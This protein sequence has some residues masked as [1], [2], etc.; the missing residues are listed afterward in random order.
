M[1]RFDEIKTLLDIPRYWARVSPDKVAIRDGRSAV[2]YSELERNSNRIANRIVECGIQPGARI[3]YV[4]R[5]SIE[6]FEI[7]FGA[8]KAG[9][10]IAPFNW[11]CAVPELVD[12]V[13]DA[14]TPLVFSEDVYS[15]PK[16][17]EV[18]DKSAAAFELVS[19]NAES[20][21]DKDLRSIHWLGGWANH[22]GDHNPGIKVHSDDVALLVYT[23]GTT[24]KPKG[25]QYDHQAFNYSFL[26][27]S[28]EPEM[29]W[30]PDDVGL[31]A[32]PNFHLGGNWVLLPAL[33]HGATIRTIPAFDPEAVLDAIER[34]SATIL[35]LVPT[36]LQ[37]LVEH[38]KAAT[39]NFSSLQRVI[40]F[41]SPI[42]ADVMKK[43]V[44]TLGCKLNQLYGNTETWF[45]T[46]LGHEDH[47]AEQS[48]RLA[49][50]GK[51]LPLIDV[52]ICDEEGKELPVGE[53]GELCIRTP[54]INMGYLNKPEATAKA[55][56][57]GWYRSGDLAR[58]DSE[59]FIFLVDRAK[60][61][62]VSGGENIYSVEVERVLNLHPEVSLAAVIGIPDEKWGEKVTAFIV[63][64]RE[65]DVAD[66]QFGL[67]LIEHC[68]QYL[69]GY[70]VPKEIMIQD[71]LPLNPTG[72]IQKNVLR[73][74]YWGSVN[75]YIR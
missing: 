17:L 54:T 39:T 44:G 67:E 26:C 41:G 24:G 43:A 48:S 5:N 50:C 42:S 11:R 62:I 60:D 4:G 66:E 65:S 32:V 13:D 38:P 73:E 31:M 55:F 71:S 28:L 45:V 8:C 18:K 46:L 2:T 36:A 7:W 69:A 35:P 25:A 10:A 21:S 51:A 12:M 6:F 75:R 19:F 56:H 3:G 57:D 52:K 58:L 33:Y 64:A 20:C 49:S 70:K 9:C 23:S 15:T 63:R 47:L 22:V 16:M 27:M 59:G 68:R 37:M 14:G 61:M 74:P 53:V 40:Y 30:N 1:W 34:D 29:G 72:K